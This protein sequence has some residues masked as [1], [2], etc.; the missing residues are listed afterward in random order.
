MCKQKNGV[1]ML[2]Y[3]LTTILELQLRWPLLYD[4]TWP[5]QKEKQ[6]GGLGWGHMAVTDKGTNMAANGE[7]EG[8]LN[9]TINGSL[10]VGLNFVIKH[11]GWLTYTEQNEEFLWLC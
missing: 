2:C 3:V 8:G 10:S 5:D 7:V 4:I 6:N 11:T 9:V 1:T